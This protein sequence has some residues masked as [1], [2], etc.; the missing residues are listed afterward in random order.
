MN[1]IKGIPDDFCHKAT[2]KGNFN[3]E[4]IYI[5]KSDQ[6]DF[7]SLLNVTFTKPGGSDLRALEGKTVRVIADNVQFS[8]RLFQI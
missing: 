5:W 3:C 7:I 4:N 8:L 2:L 1:F 6:E